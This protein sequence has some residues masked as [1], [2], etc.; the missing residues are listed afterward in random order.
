M[1]MISSQL[2]FDS[3]VSVLN[4]KQSHFQ[5]G[6]SSSNTANVGSRAG[7]DLPPIPPFKATSKDSSFSKLNIMVMLP[8]TTFTHVYLFSAGV[9]KDGRGFPL[10]YF[11]YQIPY[12]MSLG[13]LL[14]YH[15]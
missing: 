14:C 1:L 4:W 9:L 12:N 13:E 10:M 6:V 2:D 8:S 11:I 3:V 5:E 7:R 15:G